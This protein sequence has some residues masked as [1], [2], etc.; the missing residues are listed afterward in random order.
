MICARRAPRTS[1]RWRSRSRS[2]SRS[3]DRPQWRVPEAC[4]R[5]GYARRALL[6]WRRRVLPLGAARR[7]RA[8]AWSRSETSSKQALTLGGYAFCFVQRVIV[9]ADS[10]FDLLTVRGRVVQG[11]DDLT[12][13]DAEL[14]GE[15]L[16]ALGVRSRDVSQRRDDLP[17]VR[18]S[19]E[20][21]TAT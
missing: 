14:L 4:G 10:S 3:R 13:V 5:A 21:C 6:V 11:D 2:L 7:P 19:G 16:D 20:G 18:P 17:D 12:L 15:L 9:G 8:A 1:W